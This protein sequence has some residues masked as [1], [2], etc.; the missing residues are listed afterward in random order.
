MPTNELFAA[1]CCG[2]VGVASLARSRRV[3]PKVRLWFD[4]V[5]PYAWNVARWLVGIASGFEIDWELMSLAILNEGRQLPPPEQAHMR[6]SRQ[7]GRL[8]VAIRDELG[9]R[10]MTAAYFS[11]GKKYFDRSVTVDAQLIGHVVS[12]VGA[13]HSTA[14]ALVNSDLDAVVAQSHQAGQRAL[15]EKTGSPILSIDGHAFFGPVLTS[16]PPPRSAR[17]LFDA[18]AVLA[19]TPEFSQ[20]Q[21]PR[22]QL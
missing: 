18:V 22:A 1:G 21:R 8:M 2:A 20:L 9:V 5:C 6:D 12:A 15:G 17:A 3:D 11:F 14:D 7:V 4:P 10:G 13:R 19:A 16:V